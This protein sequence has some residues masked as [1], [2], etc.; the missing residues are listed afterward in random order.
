MNTIY[1]YGA[2]KVNTFGAKT[3]ITHS[4]FSS[5]SFG[6]LL[7][8]KS[9]PLGQNKK[10]EAPLFAMQRIRGIS[11]HSI[12]SP[13]TNDILSDSVTR[14]K[15]GYVRK[16]EK[17]ALPNSRKIQ[18]FLEA[19]VQ[20]GYIQNWSVELTNKEGYGNNVQKRIA[21]SPKKEGVRNPSS[22]E[23][24]RIVV[25]LKYNKGLPAIKG[26]QILSKPSKRLYFSKEQIV[27]Y[28]E[29]QTWGEN[30]TLFLSTSLGIMNHRE[31]L[32]APSFDS[33]EGSFRRR[34]SEITGGE[35]LC[36]VW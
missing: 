4:F 25:L 33:S 29:K 7:E 15:N 34:K 10:K 26:I 18:E 8:R 2:L 11:A 3:A 24:K 12:P 36:L 32:H 16:L 28:A 31:A 30:W 9:H 22:S 5:L 21:C 27:I 19:L 35:G 14:I 20:A 13:R 6:S 17:I 23:E 1:P